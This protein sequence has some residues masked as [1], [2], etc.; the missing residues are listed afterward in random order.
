M[1]ESFTK[2]FSSILE[3][4][5]W[6]EDDSTRLVWVTML[7]MAD[8]HGYVGASVLGLAARAR[9][10]PEQAEAAL[11]KFLAPDPHSRSKQHEGRRIEVVERGWVLLNYRRFRDARD[12]ERRRE[13]WRA[14]KQRAAAKRGKSKRRREIEAFDAACGNLAPDHA[15]DRE[16]AG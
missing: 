8:Q 12:Q 10:T 5:I 14:S 16:D 4:T 3:S 9:V 13:Q 7:A 15:Y 2:L 1:A 6:F 11:R